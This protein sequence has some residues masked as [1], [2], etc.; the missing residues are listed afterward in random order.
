MRLLKVQVFLPSDES[1][2]PWVTVAVLPRCV[3][4]LRRAPVL[5]WDLWS[6]ENVLSLDNKS[7]TVPEVDA[8]LPE[9]LSLHL[10]YSLTDETDNKVHLDRLKMGSY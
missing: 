4:Q 1:R 3:H 6:A 5:R 8:P 9:T 10:H 7:V 2:G